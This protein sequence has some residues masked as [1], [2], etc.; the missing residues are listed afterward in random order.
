MSRRWK[1]EGA[2]LLAAFAM[3]I[4]VPG[5][6]TDGGVVGGECRTGLTECNGD[7]FDT[8]SDDKHCGSC[9]HVCAAGVSCVAGVCGG[10]GSAGAGGTGGN[11]GDAEVDGSGTDGGDGSAGDGS[12]GDGSITDGSTNDV[13]CLPPFDT[14]AQ[15]GDCNTQCTGATP[16]CS[17]IDDTFQCVALCDPPLVAC[18]GQCVDTTSDPNH[19]GACFNKCPSG[20]CQDSKCV[21]ATSGHIVVL[22]SSYQQNFQQSPQTTIIG[23]AVFLPP[24]NPVRIL[25]YAEHSPANIET[26][27]NQAI[28]WAAQQKGRTF[29]T[30]AA[31]T[32]AMVQSELVKTKYEV[33]LVY[34]QT[35]APAG[36]LG[37]AGTSWAS[38]IANFVAV[39][40][41]VVVQ[42]G[43]GGTGDMKSLLT[44]AGL[45]T[46]TAQ[47]NIDGSL[48]YNQAPFDA[49]GV[50]VI[51]PYVAQ[52]STCTLTTPTPP[53]SNLVFVVTD[54]APDAGAG[55]PVVVHR[56]P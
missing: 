20:I 3:A 19:C 39:G 11:S 37:P 29:Q 35:T 23:N 42:S 33:L 10:D 40:G 44:N 32:A 5:A 54:A 36:T 52:T 45:L 38:A 15:C 9:E 24:Q 22:C 25:A 47:T 8:T 4:L 43:G 34:D 30:T 46:V 13:E 50:N 18:G 48:L 56:I 53:G 21:G 27:V 49:L 2:L 41:V 1:T 51:S 17:P 55:N 14:P 6:C 28:G 16:L 7:C 26:S 12:A 31:N